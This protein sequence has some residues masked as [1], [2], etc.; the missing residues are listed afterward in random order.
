MPHTYY[1]CPTHISH[2][3]YTLHIAHTKHTPNNPHTYNTIYTLYSTHAPHMHI[4]CS[5]DIHHTILHHTQISLNAPSI[6]SSTLSD[7][8]PGP[9]RGQRRSGQVSPHP[10]DPKALPRWQKAGRTSSFQFPISQLSLVRSI[11]LSSLSCVPQANSPF[12][13]P[14]QVPGCCLHLLNTAQSQQGAS[15]LGLCS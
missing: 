4:S 3:T 14:E 10:Q 12:R 9:V 15:P 7:P 8:T 5:Q 6:H 11:I 13:V 1:T 2:S